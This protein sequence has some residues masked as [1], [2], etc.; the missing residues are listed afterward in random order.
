MSFGIVV[1]GVAGAAALGWVVTP[2]FRRDA[3]EVER[4]AR[5]L[6]ER[7]ELLSRKEQLLAALRDLEDDR[8][9]GKMN[10]TDYREL[11]ARLT[12]QAAEVLERLDRID[13][14]DRA[15]TVRNHPSASTR[16]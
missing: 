14:A 16:R 3:V 5:V 8:D 12:A 6:S 15:R 4:S 13:E 7:A 11:E 1:A 2:L 10:A 9:T